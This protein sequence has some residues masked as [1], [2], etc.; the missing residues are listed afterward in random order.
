M[1]IAEKIGAAIA[2]GSLVT[3][4]MTQ[5]VSAD[6]L[7]ISGNGDGSSNTIVSTTTQTCD[8]KQ[9]ANTD[10][11]ALVSAQAATGGNEASGNTGSGTSITTG[12][13]T[14]SASVTV[15]G[16]S[17]LAVNPCCCQ[18]SCPQAESTNSA[19]ISGN[20]DGSTNTIVDSKSKTSK[21]KQKA[22]TDVLADVKSK[23]KTGKNKSNNNTGGTNTIQ[24]GHAT[25]T[26]GVIVT[27][28]T[29]T[30]LNP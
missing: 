21:V 19:L 15:T 4:L 2:A 13:A 22:K 28:G 11:V 1:N 23:A 7:E 16:G 20:G 10:V 6:T 9:T 17:N 3:L 18:P 26:A 25:S 14:S 27:G 30:L 29:N 24:T 8:V 5:V 12:D